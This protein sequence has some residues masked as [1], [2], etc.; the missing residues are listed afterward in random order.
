MDLLFADEKGNMLDFPGLLMLGR[1]GTSL[2]TPG[3]KDMIPLP[4]GAS[5]TLVPGRMPVGINPENA[6][7][8]ALEFN[9]YEDKKQKIFAV[10]ALLPQGYTRTFLPA[11]FT[12]K[13]A[14]ALPLLG[15]TAVAAENGK[16]YCAAMKTDEDKNWNPRYFNTPDLDK[17]VEEFRRLFP[18]NRIISQ[19]AKCAIDYSCFTAQNIFYRRWEGGIPVSPVCNA[20]CMGCISLQ[21]SECCPSPQERINFIPDIEEIAEIAIPHLKSRPENIISFGQGCEGE[22]SLQGDVIADAIKLI[23]TKVAKGTININTNAGFTDGIT[24]IAEAGINHARVSMI[25][26]REDVYQAYYRPKNYTYANVLESLEVL[27]KN[28][29]FTALNLLTFPGLND[30]EDELEALIK[31]IN[32]YEIKQVQFRNLNFDPDTF[33]KMFI[34]EPS[35]GIYTMLKRLKKDCPN[36]TFGSYTHPVL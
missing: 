24:R 2:L 5:L 17:R 36:T 16:I 33:F 25:S 12:P 23:R 34:G 9:P 27:R 3:N 8:E 19:L 10:A 30:R 31:L 32:T 4:T 28:K 14:A 13:N 7:S 22:P 20:D 18:A 15:Y 26:A 35:L 11:W 21:P 29:V 6:N 1:R